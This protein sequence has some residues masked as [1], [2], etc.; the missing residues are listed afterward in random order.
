MANRFIVLC[1]AFMVEVSFSFAQERKK[2]DRT[3]PKTE[4]KRS[5][6]SAPRSSSTSS[7]TRPSIKT[8]P[9]KKPVQ[10]SYFHISSQSAGF[11]SEGG[12]KTF[13]VSSSGAWTIS[14]NTASWGHL[15]RS[16]NTLTLRA[17]ANTSSSSR[18]DYFIIASGSKTLRV[19]IS[20]AK[21]VSFSVSSQELSFPASGGS[22]T[23]TVSA[24]GAWRIGTN[25]CGWGHL[26]ISGSQLTVQLDANTG[27]SSRTDYFTIKSGDQELRVNITQNGS[28]N[29][30]TIS[31]KSRAY[32]DTANGLTY[33]TSQIK[34]KAQCRLGGITEFG[35]G[36]VVFGS[37]GFAWMSIPDYL[38]EKL[39]EI[40]KNEGKIESITLT[41]SGYYCVVYDRNA[42]Y[43]VVPEQMK[44]KL[45]DF[46]RNGELISGVSICEN[47]NFAIITDKHM[48]AS[49]ANDHS[50]IKKASDLYGFVKDVCITDRGICV[51]CEKGIYYNNIP[52]NLEKALKD[53]TFQPDHVFFTDAGTYLV[54]SEQ[55]SYM[56]NM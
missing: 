42:W 36:V 37:N 52:S 12:T 13:T 41:N 7:S 21:G 56:Y 1:I 25:T 50:C 39:K 31:G 28:S 45:N 27:S 19:D 9:K 11:G 26:S 35:K 23:I 44:T 16:G 4:Q 30:W 15:T 14:V 29:S 43:G 33:L 8:T 22:K 49:H 48:Y 53:C 17:D 40:N 24:N 18:T 47:G 3:E 20:Q 2:I 55:G 10:Q 51:V 6:V 34:E 46:N 32:T 54:T 5:P 38:S